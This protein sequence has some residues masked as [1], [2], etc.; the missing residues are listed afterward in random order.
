[1]ADSRVRWL[2]G[3]ALVLVALRFA[4]VPWAQA[5]V[6]RRQQLEVL[7]QRLDRSAGVVEDKA[8]ILAAQ[9][10]LGNV[11]KATRA[12]FPEVEDKER[13]RLDAQRML[14]GIAGRGDV[15][16]TLFDWIVDGESAK[17]GLA[18]GRVN[19][20]LQ[21]PLDSLVAVHGQVEGEMP[22][23]AVREVK[24]ETAG[25]GASGLA[26]ESATLLLVI[27][28]FYRPVVAQVP[29]AAA[30]PSSAAGAGS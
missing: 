6:E 27:D 15:K 2:L 28:L 1:V 26:D 11:S 18:Y 30:A 19:A 17:A 29:A 25:N 3:L 9:G 20:S 14:S 21:G 23:A 7:T 5:Q 22:F 8:E 12:I 24:L 13:F 4:I 10:R 16:V